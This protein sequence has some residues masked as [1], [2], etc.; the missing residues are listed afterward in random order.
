MTMLTGLETSPVARDLTAFHNEW[1]GEWQR[2]GYQFY[3]FVE[4]GILD[5]EAFT[6]ALVS[7][8]DS[9]G[10]PLRDNGIVWLFSQCLSLDSVKN[11]FMRDILQEKG[12]LTSCV[13]KMADYKQCEITAQ[14]LQQLQ[15]S[16]N[17][18]LEPFGSCSALELRD[19]AVECF[20]YRIKCVVE[21]RVASTASAAASSSTK[22][23]VNSCIP[24]HFVRFLESSS[25]L[26][27]HR[28]W[29][30]GLDGSHGSASGGANGDLDYQ[31]L[32]VRAIS[33][34]LLSSFST[35]P[36]SNS[37]RQVRVSE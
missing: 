25:N 8:R 5:F 19:S 36:V 3:L 20:T 23:L 4:T 6:C 16:T 21:D 14:L 27:T 32:G 22:Y 1:W 7:A 37:I 26:E 31:T 29:W 24:A 12:W 18:T 11:L 2:F 34:C 33:V 13:L 10:Q 9:S 17:T 35:Q 15:A 28:N 30:T